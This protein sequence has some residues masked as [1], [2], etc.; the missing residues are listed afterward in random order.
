MAPPVELFQKSPKI[1]SFEF[2]FRFF[3]TR[4][5]FLKLHKSMQFLILFQ[6]GIVTCVV[7][8]CIKLYQQKA[9][10][11]ASSQFLKVSRIYSLVCTETSSVREKVCTR[12]W[13]VPQ[14]KKEIWRFQ[15]WG[16]FFGSLFHDRCL[17]SEGFW[18]RSLTTFW[19][20]VSWSILI[21]EWV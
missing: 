1:A 17:S 10:S 13:M 2:F 6:M 21:G 14:T 4:C 12:G 7:K 20:S 19:T 11:D 3:D 18:E 5:F 15:I 8:F 16:V 9:I